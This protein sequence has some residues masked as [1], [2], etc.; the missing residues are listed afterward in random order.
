MEEPEAPLDGGSPWPPYNMWYHV[1]ATV[2]S[3]A[4]VEQWKEVNGS[5][6]SIEKALQAVSSHLLNKVA[7][8]ITI[9][10]G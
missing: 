5:W 3:W 4:P 8:T 2:S 7:W 9:T 1:A 6:Y 10:I